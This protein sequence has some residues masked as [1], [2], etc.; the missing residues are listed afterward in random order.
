MSKKNTNPLVVIA[1]A[2]I[3][4]VV[5]FALTFSASASGM[6][7]GNMTMT[8]A[9][10]GVSVA[11]LAITLWWALKNNRKVPVAS[12]AERHAVLNTPPDPSHG[13]I[14]VY[15]EG[16]VGK[17][18]GVDI[19]VD[20]AVAAQL[21]SPRFVAID[22]PPGRHGVAAAVQGKETDP[23]AVTLAGGDVAAVKVAMILGG[24]KASADPDVVGAR[25]KLASVPMVKAD[26]AATIF[27]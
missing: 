10:I 24:V 11:V 15:R 12:D 6:R 17:M 5:S 9:I 26:G 27:Q 8:F 3:A 23:V 22:V 19:I 21:K 13:R 14:L 4:G 1:V 18:A 20:G 7:T 25:A 2:L 16:F